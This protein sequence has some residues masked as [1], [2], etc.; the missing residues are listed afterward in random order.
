M[1]SLTSTAHGDAEGSRQGRSRACSSYQ[2]SSR[3]RSAAAFSCGATAVSAGVVE[4]GPAHSADSVD[5]QRANTRCRY[6]IERIRKVT[7]TDMSAVTRPRGPL[8]PRVYWTRRLVLLA[9]AFALVFGVRPGARWGQR[10][11]HHT[12]GDS[13]SGRRSPRPRRRPPRRRRH[14]RRSQPRRRSPAA[15]PA[16]TGT[17][18][19]HGQTDQKSAKSKASTTASPLPESSGPCSTSDIVATPTIKDKAHAGKPWSSR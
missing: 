19:R 9:V 11:W 15:R 1:T 4:A 18:S 12:L 10:R 2:S 7:V 8:P 5:E 14:R 17:P 13:R 6:R 3:E 16:L